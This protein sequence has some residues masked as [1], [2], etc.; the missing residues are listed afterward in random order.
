MIPTSTRGTIQLAKTA[1]EGG[2][3]TAVFI[4]K[5]TRSAGDYPA[6]PDAEKAALDRVLAFGLS[7]GR[8][9]EIAVQLLDGPR[10]RRL[11]VIGLGNQKVFSIECLREAGAAVAKA[12][13]KNRLKSVAVYPP[14]IP[15]SLPG[16]PGAP[17]QSDAPL[18]G[19][20]A[21]A[22]GLLVG[23]FQFE[24]YHGTMKKNGEKDEPKI[25]RAH[26]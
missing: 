11:I 4:H 9:N 2:D 8:S 10:P 26:V 14:A 25:G 6:L 5:Q 12:A 3:A 16:V 18:A 1:P 20:A 22:Q 23:S 21:L 13:R 7:R 17:P 24:E 15:S 19:I